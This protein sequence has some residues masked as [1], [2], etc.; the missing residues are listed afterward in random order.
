MGEPIPPDEFVIDPAKWY[1]C[2][3]SAWYSPGGCG[4][5]YAGPTHCCMPGY[6]I[7]AWL[8]AGDECK[9]GYGLCSYLG[10][11]PQRIETLEGPFET[12]S[13]CQAT[14]CETF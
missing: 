6:A 14:G 11:A 10:L 5:D 7:L 2:K 1:C 13:E 4:V 9:Q 3:M 8:A 12:V